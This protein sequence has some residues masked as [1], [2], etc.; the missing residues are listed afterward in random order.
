[1]D[2]KLFC[3]AGTLLLCALNIGAFSR[4]GNLKV[5]TVYV[6]D[7]VYIRDTIYIDKTD[8]AVT[9]EN[10]PLAEPE[11]FDEFKVRFF[12]DLEFQLTRVTFPVGGMFDAKSGST[13]P[14]SEANWSLTSIFWERFKVNGII[15]PSG[16]KVY[17]GEWS[18]KSGKEIGRMRFELREDNRWYL[19]KYDTFNL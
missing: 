13:T 6:R 15:L 17:V 7:T 19:V 14:Y 11:N 10:G 1:M 2:K 8:V 3:I 4:S 5:D 18:K 16:D 12:D 9:K